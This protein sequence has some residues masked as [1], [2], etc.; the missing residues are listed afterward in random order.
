[1]M[2]AAAVQPRAPACR[3][4]FRMVAMQRATVGSGRLAWVVDKARRRGL[5]RNCSG[6]CANACTSVTTIDGE[7]K[8]KEVV[9]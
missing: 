6:G 4:S 8:V 1:M 7:V 9:G 5:G 2:N 3:F